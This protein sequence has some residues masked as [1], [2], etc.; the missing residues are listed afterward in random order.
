MSELISIRGLYRWDNTIFDGFN[1]PAGM[2]KSKAVADILFNCAE[3]SVIYPDPDFMAEAIAL[4]SD[5]E[6]DNWTRA[7]NAL[8]LEYNPIWNVDA[9][10]VEEEERDLAGTE[11]RTYTREATTGETRDFDA[12]E[13][14]TVDEDGTS[15]NTRT[16]DTTQTKRNT[17][18]DDLAED[19]T[20][21]NGVSGYNLA[22]GFSDA[23]Q[24]VRGRTNTGTQSD[25]GT[26]E[27]DGT[28]TDAGSHTLDRTEDVTKTEDETIDRTENI[29]DTDDRTTTDTGTITRT[30][31]RQG[32][33]GV[34]T[35][36]QMLKEEMEI[37]EI[38]IYHQITK[39]F[40]KRFC[41]MVY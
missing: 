34:T 27:D 19:E 15:G 30:T 11:G 23:D 16:L 24:Q 5:I 1:V 18:T 3:L 37:A 38:N 26:I 20:T 2:S 41:V 6:L 4:W 13:G 31:T 17:R 8:Q 21:T 35:S 29:S 14:L 39:S 7:W 12:T 25:A 10:I 32:N 28:I 22:S 36:Q 9:N 40:K 33:I